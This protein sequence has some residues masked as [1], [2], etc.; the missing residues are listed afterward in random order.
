[1]PGS[2]IAAVVEDAI[3]IYE[4][5]LIQCGHLLE[6]ALN[7]ILDSFELIANKSLDIQADHSE[8]VCFN[9]C[10]WS[11]MEVVSIQSL[12]SA[13]SYSQMSF[14]NENLGNVFHLKLLF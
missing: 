4:S 13:P 5:N 8:F 10:S 6:N 2:C 12:N 9:S 3:K 7:A 1:M 14:E 11:R